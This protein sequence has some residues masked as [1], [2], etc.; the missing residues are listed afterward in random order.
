M[1]ME[2]SDARRN[3]SF[4]CTSSRGVHAK[5]SRM[6]PFTRLFLALLKQFLHDLHILGRSKGV[7]KLLFGRVK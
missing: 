1:D 5:C 2:S 3:L 4:V 6:D 7:F